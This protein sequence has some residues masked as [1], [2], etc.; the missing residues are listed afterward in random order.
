MTVF[1]GNSVGRWKTTP[2]SRRGPVT[3]VP[4]SVIVPAVCGSSPAATLSRL[5][6]PQPDGPISE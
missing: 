2:T 5:D 3:G 1:Q 6:L 4:P